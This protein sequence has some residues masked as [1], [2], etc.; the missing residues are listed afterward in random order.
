MI[1]G[2]SNLHM[3]KIEVDVGLI[4][5]DYRG[6][7]KIKLKNKSTCTKTIC[8]GSPF[9]QLVLFLTNYLPIKETSELFLPWSKDGEDIVLQSNKRRRGG[10]GSTGSTIVESGS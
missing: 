3:N 7:L 4:D 10:F 9:A 8:A 1:V 6:A 5:T 2:R